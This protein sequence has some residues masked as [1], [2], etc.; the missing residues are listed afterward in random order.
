MAVIIDLVTDENAA[1]SITRVSDNETPDDRA[2][3]TSAKQYFKVRM[4]CM[5]R[6]ATAFS[7]QALFD[8]APDYDKRAI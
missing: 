1:P 7:A 3:M 6:E 8:Q 5:S 4:S 2:Y